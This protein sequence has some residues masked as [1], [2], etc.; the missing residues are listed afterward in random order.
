M[1]S[2]EICNLAVF[3]LGTGKEIA[4]V[5]T[6]NSQEAN[7]CRRYYEV[8]RDE[9]LRD[10]PWPFASTTVALGL[11]EADPND[12]W[13][14]SYRY[15]ANCVRIRRIL[16][17]ERNENR[18]E[19]EPYKI[20]RDGTGSLIYTDMDDAEIEYTYRET[21]TGRYPSD[22]CMALAYRIA[23]YIAP[24]LSGGDPLRLGQLMERMFD[25]S[26]TKAQKNASNEQQEEEEPESEFAR[27]RE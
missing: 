5:E 10:Y 18:Q 26:I 19:R 11:V 24:R 25:M 9:M 13:G 27:A 4:N 15:P 20:G 2:T 14:Y 22:F 12:E 16:G 6:E 7:A 8:A 21:D 3:H 1:T 23:G 17:G